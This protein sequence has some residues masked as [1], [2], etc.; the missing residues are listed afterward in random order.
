MHEITRDFLVSIAAFAALFGIIYV[1]LMTRY[2][3]RMSML[4]K[5]IDPSQFAKP[6]S[7]SQSLKIG[8]LLI[9]ISFGI[10]IGNFLYKNDLLDKSEAY[11]SMILLFGG[12]SLIIHFL[13]EKKLNK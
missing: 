9:F 2:R 12:S 8:M 10:L 1:Y 4:D 13:I 5:G 6:G 3:E 11:F 7:K